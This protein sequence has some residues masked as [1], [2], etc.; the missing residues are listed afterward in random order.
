MLSSSV[1][2]LDEVRD[3]R[4]VVVQPRG[5]RSRKSR[6][7]RRARSAKRKSDYDQRMKEEKERMRVGRKVCKVTELDEDEE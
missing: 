6:T 4:E 3:C 7:N 1:S 2:T 5:K